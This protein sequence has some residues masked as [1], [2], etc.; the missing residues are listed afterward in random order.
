MQADLDQQAARV[1]SMLAN[2][3]IDELLSPLMVL[4]PSTDPGKEQTTL[5]TP[6]D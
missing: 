4:V 1:R 3:D 6:L 5:G 2:H